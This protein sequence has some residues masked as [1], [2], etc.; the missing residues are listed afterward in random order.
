VAAFILTPVL[1][2][3]GRAPR[4]FPITQRVLD[5][6]RVSVLR[7]HYYSPAV[8]PSDIARPLDVPRPL[9]G[10]DMNAEGQL[11]L[12]QE[13]H[14]TDE[15]LRIP[16]EQTR[17]DAYAYHNG[18]FES[19]DGE[20]LYNVVRHFKP[21]RIVEIGCGQSTLMALLAEKQNQRNNQGYSC[22]HICVEPY[23]QPWLENTGVEVIRTRAEH[24][25]PGIVASLEENDILFIDSSHV[26]RPQGDVLHEYLFL[27][28]LLRPGVIVHAHD[29]FTP[30][31]YPKEWVIAERRLWNEQYLLEAF[32]S[33]N[34]DFEILAAVNYLSHEHREKL[35]A[36]CPVLVRETGREPGS[37]WF[38]RRSVD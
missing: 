9:P 3:L 35:A 15:L 16:L 17:D 25:D 20:M 8:I 29:I 34:R 5:R 6:A 36:A 19:G 30:R 26:I 32:L 21:K 27:L 24:V 4:R 12:I 22:Q 14:Y 33:F 28:G 1:I 10:I 23:E 13:F 2:V 31:D 18:S 11:S 38:R 7:H 37:F